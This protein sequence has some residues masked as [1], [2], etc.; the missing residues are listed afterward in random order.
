MREVCAPMGTVCCH[1]ALLCVALTEQRP[2]PI[3]ERGMGIKGIVSLHGSGR[4]LYVQVCV[5]KRKDNANEGT[6]SPF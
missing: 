2:H 3:H 6:S 5:C 4:E 1:S